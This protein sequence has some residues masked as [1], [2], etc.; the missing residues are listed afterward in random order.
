MI[1]TSP[2]YGLVPT[3]VA[4][5]QVPMGSTRIC[6]PT[7]WASIEKTKGTYD[8]TE[9]DR[10]VAATPGTRRIMLLS[11]TPTW[12]ADTDDGKGEWPGSNRPPKDMEDWA[13]FVRA[14][15]TRYRGVMYGYEILNEVNDPLFFSGT[16]TQVAAMLDRA[17][18]EIKAI[19][20]AAVVVSPS[21]TT[22]GA[23]NY[24]TYYPRHLAALKAVGWPCDG[25][26]IHTYPPKGGTP[27]TRADQVERARAALTSAGAPNPSRIWDTESNYRMLAA[28][29]S[30]R[31]L[32]GAEAQ[33]VVA[34]HMLGTLR[35]GIVAH[36][37]GWFPRSA[38]FTST[39]SVPLFT[40]EAAVSAWQ[41]VWDW[42]VGKEY[43]GAQ[44]LSAPA[45]E[46]HLLSFTGFQVAWAENS[47]IVAPGGVEVARGY[48][49]VPSW[50]R[51]SVYA[52]GASAAVTPGQYLTVR[53][54]PVR[55]GQ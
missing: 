50:G 37:F 52:N 38:W 33:G 8:W 40:D 31:T 24:A 7:H 32:E 20:S 53:T 29:G 13:R 19:D 17:H 23:N 12:A 43:L 30:I 39:L 14:A 2:R 35:L 42:T 49:T 22:S 55:I 1:V 45:G 5:V 15:A 21:V 46:V 34:R 41:R 25:Y 28:D 26:G 54:I 9:V 47:A 51:T 6:G 44:T 11:G 36:W 4:P 16:H 10:L 18:Q 48:V 3:T 27:G